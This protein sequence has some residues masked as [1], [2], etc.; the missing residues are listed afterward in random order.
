MLNRLNQLIGMSVW[1][2]DD[3]LGHVSDVYFDDQYWVARYLLVETGSWLNARK[4]LIS[5][6]AVQ[7]IDW[8]KRLVQ[9]NL[10]RQQ[11][12]G[13]PPMDAE[14]PV[15]RQHER[16]YFGYYDY[17]YY[18]SGPFLWG[19]VPN[20]IFP[21]EMRASGN[22]GSADY[23]ETPDDPHLRSVKEVSGYHVQP[24]NDSIGHVEDFLFDHE[25]W[26][27]RYVVVDTKNW[28]PGKH[29]IIPPDWI[30]GIDWA[31]RSVNVDVSRDLVQSAPEFLPTAEL[32]RS[33]EASLHRHYERMGYWQ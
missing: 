12:E 1:T 20:P 17:P 28:W 26:A 25:S 9:V 27:I 7:S 18:W 23:P 2:A 11:V 21:A 33:Q 24:E 22:G 32:T 10:S 29:V 14:R 15:S 4:V 16:D 5:P 3:D 31:E 30:T 8:H 19:P 6:Y 13:S